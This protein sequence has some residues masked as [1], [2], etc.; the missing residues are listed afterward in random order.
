MAHVSRIRTAAETRL[1]YPWPTAIDLFCGAG[2]L[3]TGLKSAHFRVLAAVDID[4][5][6]LDTYQRNHPRVELWESAIEDLD[7]AEVRSELGLRVGEL[8]LLAGCPPCEGF[9][10]IR[11]LNGKYAVDDVRNDL[12]VDF[13]RFVRE[14]KPKAVMIENVPALAEDIRIDDVLDELSE[15]GYDSV[16]DVLNAADYGV[17]QRRRRMV[18]LAGRFGPIDFAG[19]GATRKTVR[20]AIGSLPAPSRSH[21]PLHNLTE[22]RSERIRKL[23]GDIPKDG[24]SRLDLGKRRQLGCHR[25]CDGFKDIYG[26]M[27]WKDVAPTITAGCMNPSKGRFLHPRA[28]RTITLREAALL[29]TFPPDY[30]ISLERGKYAAASLIGNA[31]PPEFVRRHAQQVRRYLTRAGRRRRTGIRAKR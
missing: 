29:Q 24:G 17:P 26:R 16:V 1:S 20:D 21:D 8:S 28:D 15:L 23:I 10:S 31:L 4:P 7:A 22:N 3:T 11:T 2:G 19:I 5:L 13:M 27:K 12:I 9:S 18:L 30:Y 14:F 25:R 6:A